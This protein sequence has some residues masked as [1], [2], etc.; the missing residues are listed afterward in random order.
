MPCVPPAAAVEKG[1]MGQA[2]R[3]ASKAGDMAAEAGIQGG[4]GAAG[5]ISAQL[6]SKGRVDDWKSV[7]SEVIGEFGGAPAEVGVGLATKAYGA[8][9]GAVSPQVSISA[10]MAAA[11]EEAAAA[12]SAP[13]PE[14]PELAAARERL[15]REARLRAEA[16]EEDFGMDGAAP[17]YSRKRRKTKDAPPAPDPTIG[18]AGDSPFEDLKVFNIDGKLSTFVEH[19]RINDVPSGVEFVRTPDEAAH[20][21]AGLRK[22]PQEHIVL[23]VTDGQGAVPP[24][25]PGDKART[26]AILIPPDCDPDL[27]GQVAGRVVTL[28]DLRG[29]ADVMTMLVPRRT[30]T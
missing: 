1:I 17:A 19:R 8:A 23:L 20:V 12:A 5:E 14:T 24:A 11:A 3:V 22:Y 25:F 16:G 27:M 7:A 29:L 9:R 2:R 28:S 18:P 26:A 6:A 13:V 30:V 15:Q 21:L 4:L 10:N